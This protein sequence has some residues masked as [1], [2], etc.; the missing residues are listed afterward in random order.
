MFLVG[1]LSMG[2]IIFY[3]RVYALSYLNNRVCDDPVLRARGFLR[4]LASSFNQKAA[5]F[6]RIRTT[7]PKSQDDKAVQLESLF[8]SGC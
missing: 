2:I 5:Q 8:A 7:V 1:R 4:G 3:L 6:L